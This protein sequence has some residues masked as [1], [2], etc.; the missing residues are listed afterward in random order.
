MPN[1]GTFVNH[2]DTSCL[3]RRHILFGT[4]PSRFNDLDAAFPDRRDVFRIWRRGKCEEEGQDYAQRL[5][6]QVVTARNFLGQQFWCSLRQTGDNTEA[7]RIR[8]RACEFG[9]A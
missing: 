8:D 6:R 4:A 3:E 9:K 7:T 1:R 2:L 5:V